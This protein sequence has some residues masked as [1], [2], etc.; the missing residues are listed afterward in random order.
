MEYH[1]AQLN[2]A[3]MLKP[4]DDPVMADFVA[5]LDPINGIADTSPGFV[6]RLQ[7]EDGNATQ[8]RILDDEHLLVNLS[9]WTSIQALKDFVYGSDHAKIMRR[10]REW[11]AKHVEAYLVLWWIPSGTQPSPA[12]A[13][14]R[15]VRLK[16]EGPGPSAFTFGRVFSAPEP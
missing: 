16:K 12:E 1:L 9:V 6:W 3:R 11:F 8:T 4:L 14:E 13:E 2:V 15:L 10:K 7:D 5:A